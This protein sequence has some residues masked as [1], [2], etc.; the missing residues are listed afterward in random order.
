MSHSM[1]VWCVIVGVLFFA[2]VLNA[3]WKFYD[4][5][6]P[7]NKSGHHLLE[8]GEEREMFY[9]PGDMMDE[10]DDL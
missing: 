2:F 6:R 1:I 9:C 10:E 5:C 3:V 7:F 8:M 4:E